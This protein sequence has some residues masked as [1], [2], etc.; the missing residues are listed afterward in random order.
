MIVRT[1][2]GRTG[3]SDGDDYEPFMKKRAAPDYGSAGGLQELFSLV[4]MKLMCHIFY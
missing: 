1:W 2:H 3:L 4:G